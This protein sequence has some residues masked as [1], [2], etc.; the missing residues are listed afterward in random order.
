MGMGMGRPPMGMG[1][2]TPDMDN[3]GLGMTVNPMGPP[4]AGY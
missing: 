4:M 2:G 3:R 1:M